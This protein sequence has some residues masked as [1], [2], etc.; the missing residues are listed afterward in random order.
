MTNKVDLLYTDFLGKFADFGKSE[1]I[2]VYANQ[3]DSSEWA[4]FYCALISNDRVEKS[5]SDPSWD[6]NYGHGLP[7]FSFYFE[8]GKEIGTYYRYSDEGIELI[9]PR[10][11]GHNEELVLS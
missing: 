4:T 9:F 6:L 10:I 3:R 1:W 5:L 7:G 2:T 11:S 8:D